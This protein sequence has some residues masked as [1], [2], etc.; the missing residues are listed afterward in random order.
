MCIII[1]KKVYIILIYDLK[2]SCIVLKYYNNIINKNNLLVLTF[3]D[4]C[5]SD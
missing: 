3:L 1:K 5:S 2:K 4:T